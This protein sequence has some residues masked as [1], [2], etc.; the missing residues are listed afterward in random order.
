MEEDYYSDENEK[1]DGKVRIYFANKL[2]NII[3]NAKDSVKDYLKIKY[4]LANR[5]F[6]FFPSGLFA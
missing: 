2:K 3:E 4:L 6:M 1:V 5:I